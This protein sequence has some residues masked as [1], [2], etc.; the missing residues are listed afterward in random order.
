M[1]ALEPVIAP[2]MVYQERKELC[3]TWCSTEQSDITVSMRGPPE[4]TRADAQCG[5]RSMSGKMGKKSDVQ[6]RRGPPTR[7]RRSET[8]CS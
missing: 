8:Q 2:Q 1:E 7:G 4:A 5:E 3:G 6:E